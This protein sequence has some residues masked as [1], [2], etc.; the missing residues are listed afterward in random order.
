MLKARCAIGPQQNLSSISVSNRDIS[1]ERLTSPKQWGDLGH[2][3]PL[4]AIMEDSEEEITPQS[5]TVSLP[6]TIRRNRDSPDSGSMY[7]IQSAD[8]NEL[9]I[10]AHSGYSEVSSVVSLSSADHGEGRLAW[11]VNGPIM[12]GSFYR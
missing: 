9:V 10:Y 4:C 6:L 1:S 5:S 2:A 8:Q 11:G 12:E 7:T 3:G